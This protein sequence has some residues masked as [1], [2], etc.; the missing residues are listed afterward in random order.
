MYDNILWYLYAD[1]QIQIILRFRIDDKKIHY[2]F[3]LPCRNKKI[4][5]SLNEEQMFAADI[6]FVVT[7][8]G[9]S[10]NP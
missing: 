9:Y 1:T 2:Y 10:E 4:K 3:L 5:C 6:S 7:K 8:L